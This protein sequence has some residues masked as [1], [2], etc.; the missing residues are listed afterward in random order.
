[1][2]YSKE[3]KARVREKILECATGAFRQ[4]GLEGVTVPEVMKRT[5]LT[6][7]GF[8]AHFESKD[9]L[10]AEACRR[11]LEETLEAFFRSAEEAPE[12]TLHAVI[13]RYVSRVHRDHPEAGCVIPALGG[14]V[15]HHPSPRVRQAFTESVEGFLGALERALPAELPPEERRQQAVALAAGMVGA[16]LMARAVA[17]RGL[18]DRIIQAAREHLLKTFAAR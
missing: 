12:G 6:H 4:H 16:V 15:A 13:R 9:A 2:P 14:E 18:S 5:G 10:V 17:D 1:M 7:G 11:G 8:Y 3:H